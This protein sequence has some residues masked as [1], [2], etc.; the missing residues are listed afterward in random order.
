MIPASAQSVDKVIDGLTEAC[1][2]IYGATLDASLGEYAGAWSDGVQD[3]QLVVVE[4]APGNYMPDIIVAVASDV[5]QSVERP[6]MGRNRVR[7]IEVQVDV[8]ISVAIAGNNTAAITARQ[9][10]NAAAEPLQIFFRSGDETLGGACREAF[11]SSLQG[12]KPSFAS[13]PDGGVWGRVAE[14]T[15][16]VTAYVRN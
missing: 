8:V 2:T 9:V 16:T 10:A 3:W 5:R 14:V 4:G 1:R 7:E 13:G 15:A 12:P 11:I 6:V